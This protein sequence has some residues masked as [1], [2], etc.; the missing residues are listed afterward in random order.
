[1]LW[2]QIGEVQIMIRVLQVTGSLG[3]AGVEAV[4]MNYYRN[5]D[6]DKVQFDFITC[7]R[8]KQR[9]DDE[10]L[11]AGGR[12]YRLPSRS[13]SPF[14]YMKELKK[15]LCENEYDI[16]HIHQNSA[17]MC[18][19]AVV[20]RMCHVKTIVGH[21][22]STSCY[23]KWQH[24]LFK[25]FV[26]YFLTD[27]FA[28][29]KE[30]GEWIFGKKQEVKILN[31]AIDCERYRWNKEKRIATRKELNLDDQFVV[32]YV[33]KLHKQKNPYK[34]IDVFCEIK[35]IEDRACLLFVGDG[36]ERENMEN[37]VQKKK[38][39]NDVL[40]LGQ[41]DD[42]NLLMMAMDAFLFPSSYEGLGL[43]AI[44]AQATGLKCIVSENVPAPDLTGLMKVVRLEESN[45]V[46]A[47]KV[48]EPICFE[49][50]SAP[51]YIRMGGYDIAHEAKELETFYLNHSGMIRR[52]NR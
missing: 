5:V 15:V 16:V 22:H 35:K 51:Q 3:Y 1:M 31:N 39:Q 34:I 52:G 25:P 13:R 29:S 32:G 38:L 24:Y 30:A 48:L 9:Y 2:R 27:C 41:R 49:R 43:V 36:P 23:V 50:S 26:N 6:K 17:S 20:A 40:F 37:E 33:G 12:I 8:E 14:L 11:E 45:E 4:V 21:S 46:W 18:M 7:S 47:K 44:E 19:D 28:C 10:I 42:A